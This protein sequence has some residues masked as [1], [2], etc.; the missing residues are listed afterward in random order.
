MTELICVSV[1]KT[2]VNLYI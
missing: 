2:R 1:D